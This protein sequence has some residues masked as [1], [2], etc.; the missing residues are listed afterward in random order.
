M[1]SIRSCSF[2]ATSAFLASSSRFFWAWNSASIYNKINE[3]KVY[4]NLPLTELYSLTHA[5]S[6][7]VNIKK[8]MPQKEWKKKG[9]NTLTLCQTL[10][11]V[12]LLIGSSLSSW[13]SMVLR[14]SSWR[15]ISSSTSRMESPIWSS[16]TTDSR[17]SIQASNTCVSR[18][19]TWWKKED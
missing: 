9:K 3:R 5:K 2:L 19:K 1:F 15:R 10:T 14:K 4:M 17:D 8:T 13:A 12:N 18:R 16:L 7:G 6:N 11:M